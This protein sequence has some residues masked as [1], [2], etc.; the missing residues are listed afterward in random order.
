MSCLARWTALC[1]VTG[2]IAG[3]AGQSGVA[4]TVSNVQPTLAKLCKVAADAGAGFSAAIGLKLTMQVSSSGGWC[5][6]GTAVTIDSPSNYRPF[7]LAVPTEQPGHGEMRFRNADRATFVEYRPSAGYIGADAFAFR[8]LPGNG[9][10]P[11]S[12]I[13]TP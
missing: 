9:Y 2:A 11:V 1:A 13:V 7:D 10:F 8:L 4:P 12:V 5:L 3:C 6:W